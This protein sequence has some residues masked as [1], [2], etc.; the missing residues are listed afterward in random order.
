MKATVLA[1]LIAPRS[2]RTTTGPSQ[3]AYRQ[4]PPGLPSTPQPSWQP[5]SNTNTTQNSRVFRRH[6]LEPSDEPAALKPVVPEIVLS[7]QYGITPKRLL[8]SHTDTDILSHIDDDISSIQ[9]GVS[10][11]V[12][13]DATTTRERHM[14][15]KGSAVPA[16]RKVNERRNPSPQAKIP[17]RHQCAKPSARADTSQHSKLE[18]G[19]QTWQTRCH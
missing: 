10:A 17:F 9:D 19:A 6:V 1:N 18:P 5:Y 3:T 2:P 7:I 16:F 12:M 11:W 13:S 4:H 15:C 14:E 8:L